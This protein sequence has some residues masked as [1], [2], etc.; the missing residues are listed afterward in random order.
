MYDPSTDTWIGQGNMNVSRTDFSAVSLDN[1]IY[2]VGGKISTENG[3]QT[4]DTIEALQ[5]LFMFRKI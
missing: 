5:H 3:Q 2:A 1:K 4:T